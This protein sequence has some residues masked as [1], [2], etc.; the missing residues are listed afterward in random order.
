MKPKQEKPPDDF[1]NFVSRIA[2][3][4]KGRLAEIEAADRAANP[5]IK[6]GPKPKRR[7]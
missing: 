1:D 3:V 6:R 2:G 7:T 5:R 4:P